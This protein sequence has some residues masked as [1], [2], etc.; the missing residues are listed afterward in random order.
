GDVGRHRELHVQCHQRRRRVLRRGVQSRRARRGRDLDKRPRRQLMPDVFLYLGA[1]SP[2]DITLTDPTV[3][4]GG[5]VNGEALPAGVAAIAAVGT[6]IATG[7]ATTSPV[8]V[9][10]G[11]AVGTAIATGAATTAPVGVSAGS[12]VGA[13]V[14]TGAAVVS[15]NGQAATSAVGT[16]IAT[17]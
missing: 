17:G 11:S 16:A 5:G 7:A 12:A 14:A 9:S 2:S 3:L 15:P 13:P 10:A 6:A 8:G 1:A 4:S